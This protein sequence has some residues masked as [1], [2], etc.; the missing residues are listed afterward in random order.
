MKKLLFILMITIASCSTDDSVLTEIA[1]SDYYN[2]TYKAV[3]YFMN[4]DLSINNIQT[5]TLYFNSI[6]SGVATTENDYQNG[7]LEITTYE[8]EYQ[9]FGGETI[10]IDNVDY[11]ISKEY[12]DSIFYL[13]FFYIKQ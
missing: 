8:I 11:D 7:E 6:D 1:S 4:D 12:Y 13:D 9:Y 5:K 10:K 2:T 3:T